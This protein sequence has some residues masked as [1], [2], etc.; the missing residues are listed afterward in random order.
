LALAQNYI[1]FKFSK[2]NSSLSNNNFCQGNWTTLLKCS[3]IFRF[4]KWNLQN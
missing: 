1:I 4:L 2:K 3:E